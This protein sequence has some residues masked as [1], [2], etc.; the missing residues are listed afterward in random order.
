MEKL[1]YNLDRANNKQA[2]AIVAQRSIPLV[3][4]LLERKHEA[5]YE[6]IIRVIL[7]RMMQLNVIPQV[8]TFSID[9]EIAT[10]NAALTVFHN[11]IIDGCFYHLTQITW[12]KIQ[13]LR[14]AVQYNLQELLRATRFVGILAFE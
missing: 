5:T 7:K 13:E 6:E 14:L 2:S 10:H 9:F 1:S 4:A 8:Q 3:Y 11:R 12:R